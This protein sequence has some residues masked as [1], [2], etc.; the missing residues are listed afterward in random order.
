MKYD[1]CGVVT[2]NMSSPKQNKR[3]VLFELLTL[4]SFKELRDNIEDSNSEIIAKWKENYL[5]EDI[6]LKN[7][8]SVDE[9]ALLNELDKLMNNENWE[10]IEKLSEEIIEKLDNK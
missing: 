3:D 8:F 2:L 6:D 7:F 5:P 9:I 1:K 4:C 10:K